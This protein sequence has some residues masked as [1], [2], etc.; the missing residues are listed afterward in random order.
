MKKVLILG[1]AGMFAWDMNRVLE[2]DGGF[3]PMPLI[4]GQLDITDHIG[5]RERIAAVKPFAVVN[6]VGP[7]VDTC[8][9]DP[10]MAHGINVEAVRVCAVSVC[11][12]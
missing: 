10:K 9:E 3:E 12:S 1:G 7:L 4:R 5:L 6:T 8:E 2:R 11:T